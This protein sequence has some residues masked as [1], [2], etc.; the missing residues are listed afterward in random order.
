MKRSILSIL[1]FI[2]GLSVSFAQVGLNTDGS[3]ANPSA[4]LDVKFADKGF[5]P[6]RIAIKARSPF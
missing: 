5:L 3:S 1:V 2:A 6:P 4:G